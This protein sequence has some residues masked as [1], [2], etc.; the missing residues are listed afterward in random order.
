MIKIDFEFQTDHGLYR[1]ALYFPDDCSPSDSEI[2][3][4]KQQRLQAWIAL[5][6]NP[7]AT[8]SETET[9]IVNSGE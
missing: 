7:T 6:E 2:E 8:E 4:L 5:I 3:V 1:D 9:E